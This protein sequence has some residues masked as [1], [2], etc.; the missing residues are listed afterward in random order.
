MDQ[1]PDNALVDTRAVGPVERGAGPS[2]WPADI[3]MKITGFQMSPAVMTKGR[4]AE[5]DSPGA[6]AAQDIVVVFIRPPALACQADPGVDD[7]QN[8]I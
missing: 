7:V 3:L 8:V 6:M 4:E 1:F 2:A 5:F